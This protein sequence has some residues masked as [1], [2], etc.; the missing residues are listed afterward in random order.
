MERRS[1]VASDGTELSYLTG[2]DGPP[3][4][5]LHGWSQSA[6][7]FSGQFLDFSRQHRVFA[8]D[9]RGHG[10]SKRP[11]HGYRICRF[12]K[13]L[14]DLTAALGLTEFDVLAHSLGVSA[15]WAYLSM[16]GDERG[17]RRMVFVDEPAALLAR[18]DWSHETCAE[19]GAIVP[20]LE[21]LADFTA[22]VR[23]ADTP[24]AHAAL[25][26]PYFTP[27]FP[28]ERRRAAAVENLKLPRRHA[29]VLLEDNVIQDWR[30]VVSTI[31]TPVLVVASEASPHPLQS[32]QWIAAQ[33]PR[34][35]IE[36]IPSA[37]GGSH[38]AYLE[39]PARFNA[40][41]S[42]FLADG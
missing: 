42:R 34:A 30:A 7:G 29:A 26:Q 23:A 41:V 32:Q 6:T 38:F 28:E 8:L 17:P 37:E 11:D 5:M 24:Q 9:W 10:E 14:Y 12:A 16:F 3:I 4:V 22:A 36:L 2:G 18:P 31:R 19:A 40:P 13:D 21:A 20:S 27:G 39:N 25:M 1:F 33:I 15:L 35:E